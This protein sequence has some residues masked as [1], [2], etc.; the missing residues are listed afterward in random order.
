MPPKPI[1]MYRRGAE[2]KLSHYQRSGCVGTGLCPVQG[3]RS[4]A[5]SGEHYAST[6][7]NVDQ[8]LNRISLVASNPSFSYKGRPSALARKLTDREPCSFSQARIV[9]MICRVIPRLR[10][11]GSV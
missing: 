5:V 1:I 9:I 3:E 2:I 8:N 10:N 11:S 4:S 6:V 7:S